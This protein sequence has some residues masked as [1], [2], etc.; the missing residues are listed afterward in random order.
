[1]PLHLMVGQLQVHGLQLQGSPGQSSHP[2]GY[3]HQLSL[4][5][6]M[7]ASSNSS[8]SSNLLSHHFFPEYGRNHTLF[9]PKNITLP[10]SQ[11]MRSHG[12]GAVPVYIYTLGGLLPPGTMEVLFLL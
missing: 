9:L 8:N 5:V 4:P 3:P 7:G 6:S 1:M 12:K 10:T 11:E 2:S